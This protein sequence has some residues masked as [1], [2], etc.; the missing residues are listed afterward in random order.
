MEREGE[1]ELE[2]TSFAW[3]QAVKCYYPKDK[4]KNK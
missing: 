3:K 2:L 1:T 4:D